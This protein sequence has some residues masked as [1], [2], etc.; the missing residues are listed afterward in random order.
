MDSMLEPCS[1][2]VVCPMIF[3]GQTNMDGMLEPCSL[4]VVCFFV[5]FTGEDFV[6][7]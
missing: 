7:N 1:L 6:Y 5:F 3:D 2:N 4:N